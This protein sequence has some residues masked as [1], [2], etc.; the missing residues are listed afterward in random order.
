MDLQIE[1]V[2]ARAG[3]QAADVCQ[4]KTREGDPIRRSL[5][6]KV[7]AA[8]AEA[9]KLKDS[10]SEDDRAVAIYWQS[11]SDEFNSAFGG[12]H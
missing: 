8:R 4:A 10:A 5:F 11:F 12:T 9:Q 1:D 3:K 7:Q 6:E 2:G